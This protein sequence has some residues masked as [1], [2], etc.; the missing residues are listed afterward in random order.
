MN[1]KCSDEGV[2]D[3]AGLQNEKGAALIRKTQ[4]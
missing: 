4:V 2:G 1:A 3:T